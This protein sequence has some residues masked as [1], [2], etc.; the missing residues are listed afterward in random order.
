MFDAKTF[1][2]RVVATQMG[3]YEHARRYPAGCGHPRAGQSFFIKADA[4]RKDKAGQIQFK[5]GKP[6]LPL[7]VKPV[8]LES[9][10]EPEPE[11]DS[12]QET[13]S[14]EAE[15]PAGATGAAKAPEKEL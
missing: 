5:N 8:E 3:Y 13:K 12:E 14:E 6:V 15:K 7:W 10:P 11:S 1:K 4:L 9:K 2:L